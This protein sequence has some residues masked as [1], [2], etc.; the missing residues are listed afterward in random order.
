M[1]GRGDATENDMT[2]DHDDDDRPW[3]TLE[4]RIEAG[5][6]SDVQVYLEGL[7]DDDVVRAFM[8]LPGASQARLCAMLPARVAAQIVRKIPDPQAVDLLGRLEPGVSAAILGRLRSDAQADLLGDLDRA[9]ADSILSAMTP[10]DARRAAALTRYPDDVAGGLMIKEHLTFPVEFTVRNVLEDLR[11]HADRYRDYAVQYAY[12]TRDGR[13]H[14]VLRLRDLFFAHPDRPIDEVMRPDPLAIPD[15]ADLDALRSFFDRNPYF[16]APVVD[17]D[18][19]LVGIVTRGAVE[20]ARADR[21]DSDFLKSR[22]IVGG[23][24]FRTMPLLARSRRRLAWLSVNVGLN[25]LA[26]SVIA[27]YQE[28]LAAVIALAVFLPIIS[29]MS[30]CSGNQAVAVSMR[31][32]TLGLVKPGEVARVWLQEISVGAINGVA[33]GVLV[34][35]AAWLWK[36][37]PA[38]GLVVGVAMALNTVV[39]V[40]VG[41][42][43][44]LG[45]RR[46]EM[47][48]ALASGP[49]LT[50]V[51]DMSGFFLVLSI[52]TAMM[53]YLAGR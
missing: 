6:S 42:T 4:A 38:L 35:L 43:V 33:L 27:F 9:D 26:A 20:H 25:I 51:T 19:R 3:E 48:P 30:G 18:H 5:D 24:E 39:A 34:A 47:D 1:A 2:A 22:G 45:L 12:V 49:I 23:E 7:P 41:G 32:L 15:D 17:G 40:S 46:F 37:N 10:A 11:T 50:T 14:G 29:D 31:E 21:S 53:P 28:T 44:P 16:G 13:L 52:A 8:R 36:G